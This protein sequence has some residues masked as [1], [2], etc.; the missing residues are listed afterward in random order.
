MT[1]VYSDIKTH[2]KTNRKSRFAGIKKWRTISLQDSINKFDNNINKKYNNH[3]TTGVIFT[4]LK[5]L[6]EFF[7][8]NKDTI[9]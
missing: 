5:K 6:I 7:K 4:N 8:K 9:R 3:N 1:V 2:N